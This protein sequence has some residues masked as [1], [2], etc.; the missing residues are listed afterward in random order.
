MLSQESQ[1]ESIT[2]IL[3]FPNNLYTIRF[4][5]LIRIQRIYFH[6]NRVKTDED[7]KQ[8]KCYIFSKL[9]KVGLGQPSRSGPAPEPR[10][11]YLET[12]TLANKF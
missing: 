4:V 7:I 1:P 11:V 2:Q 9:P 5:F 6:L 8:N 3:S 10:S 12:I